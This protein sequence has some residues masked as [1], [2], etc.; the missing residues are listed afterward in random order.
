MCDISFHVQVNKKL[1]AGGGGLYKLLKSEQL[2]KY[3]IIFCNLLCMEVVAKSFAKS[4]EVEVLTNK[5]Q[6]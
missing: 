6:F 3:A 4:V 1:W 2:L 5:Y